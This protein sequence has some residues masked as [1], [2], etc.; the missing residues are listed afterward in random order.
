MKSSQTTEI[1]LKSRLNSFDA[2]VDCVVME[3]ITNNVPTIILER[4]NFELSRNLMLTDPQFHVLSEVGILTGA[5]LFWRVLCVGQIKASATHPTLQKTRFGWIL[6]GR[7][8]SFL[9]RFRRFKL[10]TQVFV[11]INSKSK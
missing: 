1:K 7:V 3:R 5:D 6:A 8:G 4:S 10:F 2:V 9:T 11:I